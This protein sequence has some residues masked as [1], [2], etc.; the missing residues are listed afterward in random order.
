MGGNDCGEEKTMAAT[1]ARGKA[2]VTG[3]TVLDRDDAPP[4]AVAPVPSL[5]RARN[6]AIVSAIAVTQLVWMA[7][8]A[9]VLLW[10]VL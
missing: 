10:L 2:A 3:L 6:V 9:Y 8:L 1:A 5:N 4:E 7:A